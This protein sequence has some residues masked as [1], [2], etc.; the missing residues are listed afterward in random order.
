MHNETRVTAVDSGHV[1][2]Y[3][4]CRLIYRKI[5][6]ALI[7][8][9]L[10]CAAALLVLAI[11]LKSNVIAVCSL[12]PPILLLLT[13]V[14]YSH[15]VRKR[16][17]QIETA[18]LT[19]LLDSGEDKE[20]YCLYDMDRGCVLTVNS[21]GIAVGDKFYTHEE[22]EILFATA[23]VM[24]RASFAVF[25]EPSQSPFVHVEDDFSY[26]IILDSELV[27]CCNKYFFPFGDNE[28]FDYMKKC[29]EKT[30]RQVLKNGIVDIDK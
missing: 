10:A 3:H 6:L 26:G 19:A 21:K 27:G 30:V 7:I 5:R 16:E 29:P 25:I 23:N 8:S 24:R 11:V 4:R 18:F 28:L 14:I 13:V 17:V 9:M 20:E 2:S 22:V 12:I 1:L 15:F